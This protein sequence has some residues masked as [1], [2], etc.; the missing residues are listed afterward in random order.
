VCAVLHCQGAGPALEQ[1]CYS[2]KTAVAQVLLQHW[3]DEDRSSAVS[4]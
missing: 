2:G 3:A 1:A 4:V